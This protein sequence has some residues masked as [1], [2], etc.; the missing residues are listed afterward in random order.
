MVLNVSSFGI[1][2]SAVI[3]KDRGEGGTHPARANG[4][5][6]GRDPAYQSL[7]VCGGTKAIGKVVEIR[8]FFSARNCIND[9]SSVLSKS[10]RKREC[11]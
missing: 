7:P 11:P 5:L 8:I 3:D 1:T 4:G 9:N 10:K 6:H 2:R